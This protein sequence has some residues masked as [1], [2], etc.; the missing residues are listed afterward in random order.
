M[1]R[2]GTKPNWLPGPSEG[3]SVL[4]VD[5]LRA[6]LR[7]MTYAQLLEFGEAAR[8]MCSPKANVRKP[9]RDVFVIQLK[10]ARAEWRRRNPRNA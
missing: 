5:A 6:R 10:Q 3:D 4:D 8:D 1:L 2:H 9:R 7:K